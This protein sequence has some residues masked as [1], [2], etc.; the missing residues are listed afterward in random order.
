MLSIVEWSWLSV[1]L[2][3]YTN[4]L[5]NKHVMESYHVKGE[6][7]TSFIIDSDNQTIV[8]LRKSFNMGTRIFTTR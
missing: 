6:Y 5:N 3:S 8:P 4:Y 2:R 1:A 7:V